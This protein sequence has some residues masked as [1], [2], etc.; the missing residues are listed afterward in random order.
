M[1]TAL[2]KKL[3]EMNLVEGL[4]FGQSQESGGGGGG[5]GEIVHKLQSALMT[6]P[7]NMVSPAQDEVIAPKLGC[8]I[9]IRLARVVRCLI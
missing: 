4:Y 2:S 6:S 7:V 3:G 5:G 8:A 1:H 9:N